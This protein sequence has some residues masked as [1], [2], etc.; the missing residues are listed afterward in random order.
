LHR[1]EPRVTES[2]NAR[3]GSRAGWQRKSCG[4]A[5]LSGP[6][7]RDQIA[8]ATLSLITRR[9]LHGTAVSRIAEEV[10]AEAPRES[11]LSEIIGC[12]Q[13]ETLDKLA[14]VVKEGRRQGTVRPDMDVRLAA[15]EIMM[16]AWAED[17]TQLMGIDEF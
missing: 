6:E 4:R 12:R 14:A 5:R 11:G 17:V 15:Y 3:E 7:R 8:D 1:P 16:R 13:V 10:G 9:G 2:S